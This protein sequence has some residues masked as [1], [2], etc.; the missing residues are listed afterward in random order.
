MAAHIGDLLG[1]LDRLGVDRG[2]VVGHDW[3]RRSAGPRRWC[4]T[5]SQLAALRS[6]TRRFGGAGWAQREKSWYML[7]IQFAGVAEQWL[8]ADECGNIRAWSGHPD[9]DEVVGRLRRAGRADRG[10]GHLPGDPA[11]ASV[12]AGVLAYLSG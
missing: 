4:P 11:A 10:A 7:L 9:A 5:G 1:V 3:A 6:G 2:A 8:S 12:A